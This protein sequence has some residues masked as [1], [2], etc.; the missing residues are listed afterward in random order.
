MSLFEVV[1]AGASTSVRQLPWGRGALGRA[2]LG[3]SAGGPADPCA[4][5]RANA[6]VH[7]P[8]RAAVLEVMLRG[9]TLRFL[10]DTTVAVCGAPF[11]LR[12]DGALVPMDTALAVHRGQRLELGA[13]SR[14]LRAMIAV[15][16]GIDAAPADPTRRAGDVVAGAG[17]APS[18]SAALPDATPIEDDVVLRACAAPESALFNAR[19][20][21]TFFEAPW[22]VLPASDRR[23]VRLEGAPLLTP[24]GEMITQGVTAGAVQVPPSGQPLVLFMDQQTTGG[25]PRIA[26]VVTLDLGRLGQLR[27]GQQV[28]FV[29]VDVQEALALFRAWAKPI[30]E[31][32]CTGGSPWT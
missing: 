32:A 23:G 18:A 3:V 1:A 5:A 31:H 27:P 11:A 25:Y 26:H 20:R 30:V 6:L 8:M 29:E 7:N 21:R 17:L 4:A 14:G 10:A 13:C 16:G 2:H 19:A 9:P 28:R 24:P 15:R 22:R 12:L